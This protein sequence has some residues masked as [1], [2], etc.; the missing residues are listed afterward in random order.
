MC[1]PAVHE[2]RFDRD[3]PE[4]DP[5]GI[6]RRGARRDPTAHE[7]L[8]VALAQYRIADHRD[9]RAGEA[10]RGDAHFVADQ[11]A[12]KVARRFLGR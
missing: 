6:G 4:P 7:H 1:T 12:R 3:S 11:Q 2:T 8:A 5:R 9:G 10:A